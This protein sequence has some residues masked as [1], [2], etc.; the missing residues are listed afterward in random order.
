MDVENPTP[1]FFPTPSTHFQILLC[2]SG[3]MALLHVVALKF[4]LSLL[5]AITLLLLTKAIII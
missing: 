1:H 2:H 3:I 5:K 4:S